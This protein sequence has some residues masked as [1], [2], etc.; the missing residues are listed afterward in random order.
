MT[1]PN[2]TDF[3]GRVTRIQNARA[4]GHGF[5]APGA[6]GRSFYQ[7][8]QPQRRSV[9]MPVLLVILC[10]LGMKG[11]IYQ[12]IGAQTYDERVSGLMAGPGLEPLGGWMM[13]TEP[14]TVFIAGQ[15]AK[16]LA[17]LK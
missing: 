6:L 11:L 4:K 7:R 17:K 13:Q 5:E 14:A 9:A 15:I 2:M 12:A 10:V 1:D 8:E 3:Y 16:G